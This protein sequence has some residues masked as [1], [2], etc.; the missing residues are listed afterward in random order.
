MD[1]QST[2]ATRILAK[3]AF[4][5]MALLLV[6]GLIVSGSAWSQ[7]F[8]EKK[9]PV[10]VTSNV[11]YGTGVINI[12]TATPTSRFL[13]VDVY[14]PDGPDA[15]LIRPGFVMLHGGSFIVGTKDDIGGSD[16]FENSLIPGDFSSPTTA[17]AEAFASRGYTVISVD[18]RLALEFPQGTGSIAAI[19]GDATLVVERI[20]GILTPFIPS[21]TPALALQ[22]YEAAL[23]D[24]QAAFQWLHDNAAAFGVDPSRI[25]LGGYSAGAI[26]SLFT[27]TM[28]GTPAAALWINSGGIEPPNLPLVSPDS[29]P[30]IFFHGTN[31]NIVDFSFAE[32]ARDRLQALG[33]P[34]EFNS[35][36]GEDHFYRI[37]STF[38]L[39]GTVE[40]RIASF[41]F[42]HM[43]LETLP[44]AA[45]IASAGPDQIVE[46]ASS[47][48]TLVALDG[49]GSSDADS[50]S[51][52][53]DGIAN[54]SWQL[55]GSEIATGEVAFVTLPDG[56]HTITL[57]VTDLSG[58]TAQ[59][60]VQI[61]VVDTTS[62]SLSLT[63]T[64]HVLWPAN[65]KMIDVVVSAG[66]TDLCD[67]APT[68]TLVSVTNSESDNSS[69]G[70]DGNTNN[71]IQ[72]ADI[73]TADFDVSLRAERRGNGD[74]RVYTLTYRATDASG[75]WV[76]E[77]VTVD[78][79]HD[80]SAHSCDQPDCDLN[81]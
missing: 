46:C 81:T 71:D 29:P 74:G 55:G 33:V 14:E 23:R 9:Y 21:Y 5:A 26:T 44:V 40:E 43:D 58:L 41:M 78:V 13:L 51:G 17:Y 30:T 12:H 69:I 52:T 50:T 31:D 1:Y 22:A 11:P 27:A 62:P 79:P 64:P 35:K 47:T 38:V 32:I 49:S 18:Y 77:S 48:G 75:N 53:N 56:N 3:S 42:T 8:V 4:I 28:L 36:V 15:P 59:T 61:A 25:A 67:L 2:R 66:A 10:K 24:T 70:G 63:V 45:P 16:T 37:D 19:G 60:T 54:Y 39:P 20:A 73:G 7:T 76:E 68:L 65:H 34:V 57:V 72:N 80:G 6:G